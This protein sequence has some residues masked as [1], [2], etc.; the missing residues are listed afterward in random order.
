MT[1]ELLGLRDALTGKVV[2]PAQAADD[3]FR[4]RFRREVRL[5]QRVPPAASATWLSVPM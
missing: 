1:P 4:T 3:E 2:H 5:S